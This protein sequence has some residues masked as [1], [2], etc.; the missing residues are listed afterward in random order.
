MSSPL[1]MKVSLTVSMKFLQFNRFIQRISTIPGTLT[2]LIPIIG[3]IGF[4]SVTM[5]CMNYLFP[6]TGSNLI[7]K[8]PVIRQA[9]ELVGVEMEEGQMAGILE[10]KG[11][12]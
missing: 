10:V 4:L 1:K 5:N 12:K 8:H 9:F 11:F 6:G 2:V 3:A 7:A